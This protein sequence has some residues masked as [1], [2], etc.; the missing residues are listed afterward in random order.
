MLGASIGLLSLSSLFILDQ[1]SKKS[2]S[3]YWSNLIQ[4]IFLFGFILLFILPHII[5]YFVSSYLVDNGYQICEA[6]S[7]SWLYIHKIVYVH[8]PQACYK[9]LVF[10]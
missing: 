2:I 7:R 9:T 3:K 1:W 10:P 5:N 8:P 4:K 6:A